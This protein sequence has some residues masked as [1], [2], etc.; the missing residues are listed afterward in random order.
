MPSV[1]CQYYRA[2]TEKWDLRQYCMFG[3]IDLLEDLFWPNIFRDKTF[4]EWL[5]FFSFNLELFDSMAFSKLF[6]LEYPISSPT[7]NFIRSTLKV[8]NQGTDRS[9]IRGPSS[10]IDTGF[11]FCRQSTFK[12]FIFQA[13]RK[14][15][16][17]GNKIQSPGP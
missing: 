17:L 12:W 2:C 14:S 15:V 13:Y 10:P 8:R 5:I 1:S 6:F 7:L 9:P 4:S 3:N 11:I 16:I